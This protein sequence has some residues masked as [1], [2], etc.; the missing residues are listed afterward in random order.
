M[1]IKV[2]VF[3]DQHSHKLGQRAS[4]QTVTNRSERIKS[5]TSSMGFRLGS[6]T[7][8]HSGRRLNVVSFTASSAED[9]S[10]CNKSGILKLNFLKSHYSQLAGFKSNDRAWTRLAAEQLH[11]LTT[12]LRSVLAIIE[13]A[14]DFNK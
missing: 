8:S 11:F 2:A 10:I 5:C 12:L 7:V 6:R 4:S 1:I 13:K 14:T 9:T 3:L